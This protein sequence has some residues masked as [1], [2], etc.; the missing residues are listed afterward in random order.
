M[1]DI[2]T[3]LVFAGVATFIAALRTV[4]DVWFLIHTVMTSV[5]FAMV[6][7]LILER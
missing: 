7:R 5:C 6:V 1:I 4:E 3:L 2:I